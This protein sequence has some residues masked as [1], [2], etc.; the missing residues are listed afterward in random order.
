MDIRDGRLKAKGKR[1]KVGIEQASAS[2]LPGFPGFHHALC[3][4]SFAH[5][6]ALRPQSFLFPD[7]E[8][9]WY[10]SNFASI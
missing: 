3:L 9:S 4:M 1:T 8:I 7:S 2:R 5:S 6:S 10:I